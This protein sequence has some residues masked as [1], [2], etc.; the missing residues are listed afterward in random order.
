MSLESKQTKL[1]FFIEH[2]LLLLIRKTRETSC[3]NATKNKHNVI[4]KI[5]I[6]KTL[7]KQPNGIGINKILPFIFNSYNKCI[8]RKPKET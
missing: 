1:F 6:M 8:F 2:A 7:K 5:L 4:L 3:L